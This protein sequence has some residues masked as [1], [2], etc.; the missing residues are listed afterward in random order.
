MQLR[1]S[2]LTC[3]TST[4]CSFFLYYTIRWR[5]FCWENL[6]ALPSHPW[7]TQVWI[8]PAGYCFGVQKSMGILRVPYF[9]ECNQKPHSLLLHISKYS[10]NDQISRSRLFCWEFPLRNWILYVSA[11]QVRNPLRNVWQERNSSLN[12]W[13][14]TSPTLCSTSTSLA[15]DPIRIPC[16]VFLCWRKK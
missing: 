7:C 12:L 16:W 9:S 14:S 15:P 4:L 6:L 1:S 10:K 3:R 5:Q 2:L 13:S 11:F 8:D